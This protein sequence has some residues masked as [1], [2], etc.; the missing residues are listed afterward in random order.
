MGIKNL[1]LAW[2]GQMP[3]FPVCHF[4][5][6]AAT[7]TNQTPN[8][9]LRLVAIAAKTETNIPSEKGKI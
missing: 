5:L 4:R 6:F 2:F 9:T 8:F 1:L 3:L 7:P